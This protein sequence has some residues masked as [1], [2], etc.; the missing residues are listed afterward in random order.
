MTVRSGI[1]TMTDPGIP[2]VSDLRVQNQ[3]EQLR[4]KFQVKPVA[5]MVKC[6][7]VL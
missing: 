5:A 6:Q 1:M 7:A 4:I 2:S 3:R